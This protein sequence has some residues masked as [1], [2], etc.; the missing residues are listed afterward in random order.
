MLLFLPVSSAKI[1]ASAVGV[2][3]ISPYAS[4]EYVKGVYSEP[5]YE[6][7]IEDNRRLFVYGR[8]ITIFFADEKRFNRIFKGKDEGR[9]DVLMVQRIETKPDSKMKTP[10]GITF[11]M[12]EEQI[13]AVYGK[14]D[15]KVL[16]T[17]DYDWRLM[18]IGEPQE[19]YDGL[20]FMTFDLRDDKITKIVCYATR[21]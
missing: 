13:V 6:A 5:T 12:S 16:G 18:Y 1:A 7:E 2:G 21:H 17:E 8:A 19:E 4:L 20:C 14:P 15:L 10:A 11:G 9:E 3:G